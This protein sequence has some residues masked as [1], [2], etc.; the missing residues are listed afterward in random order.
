MRFCRLTLAVLLL[1]ATQRVVSADPPLGPTLQ[2]QQA[3]SLIVPNTKIMNFVS[4]CTVAQTGTTAGVTCTGSGGTVTSISQGTG[5]NFSV[6][7]ITTT[8]TINLATPVSIANGGTNSGTALSAS[9]VMVSN[10]TAIVQ[11]AQGTT[12]TVLHG[13]AAGTPTYTSVVGADFANQTA[14]TVLAGPTSGGAAAP[15]FRALVASDLSG[16]GGF[17]GFWFGGTLASGAASTNFNAVMSTNTATPKVRKV[18]CSWGTAGSG[19]GNVVI[20]VYDVTGAAELCHCTLGACTTA[21]N[22]PLACDCNSGAITAGDFYANRVSPS[23]NCSASNPTNINCNNE[24]Q[25]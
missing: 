4:G 3:G 25:Q 24:L 16:S 11:G 22:T 10:G 19:T 9:A 18:T 12:T 14:N 8:G 5:M 23:T 21:G 17:G 1:L 15:G 20:Q 7:P 2:T 6:N 13:N